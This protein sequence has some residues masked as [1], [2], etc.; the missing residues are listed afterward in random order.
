MLIDVEGT[1]IFA[2]EAGVGE[3]AL[4]FIH[5]NGADHAVW[6]RQIAY[7]SP[8]RKVIALD[9]RGHGHS[10]KDP[11]KHYPQERFARDT[12]AILEAAG[13]GP[14]ILV[15]WSM[16]ASVA[17]KIA[18]L[19][20]R[21]VAGVVTVDHNIE[22][23]KAEL[24]LHLGAYDSGVILEGLREDFAGRGFRRMVDSWFPEQGPEIDVLKQWLW[25]TGMHAG[26][27]TVLGIRGIG[28]KEDRRAWLS[29]LTVP[30]LILQGGASYIGG[31]VIGEYANRLIPGSELH[32]FEGHGHAVFLTAADEFNQVLDEW[33]TRVFTPIRS[34]TGVS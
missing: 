19:S 21:H 20:P 13:V 27:D 29:S 24:G 2:L 7:F 34:A 25:E 10:G 15:G 30:T 16:G 12:I 33:V 17:A 8:R 32:V 1:R 4:V 28:V 23:A 3:P 22:S 26:Q 11:H 9:L 31:K 18:A 6:H 5:G 14:S